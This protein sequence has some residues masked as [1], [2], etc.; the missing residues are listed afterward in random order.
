MQLF[1]KITIGIPAKH[2]AEVLHL[3]KELKGVE[4]S[5]ENF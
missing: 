4:I 5:E 1:C 2:L 3:F